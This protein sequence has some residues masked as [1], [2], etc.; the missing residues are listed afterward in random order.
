[1]GRNVKNGFLI[2]MNQF[3][4]SAV[5]L[6]LIV[7]SGC[8]FYEYG[9]PD[10]VVKEVRINFEVKPDMEIYLKAIP[11]ELIIRGVKGNEAVASMEARCPDPAGKCAEYFE[12]LEFETRLKDNRLTVKPNKGLGFKGN[13]AVKTILSIP[14]VNSLNV[15]M[16]AGETKISGINVSKLYLDM[17]AGEVY[18]NVENLKTS[19]NVDLGAG[20]VNITI[21]ED[22]VREVDVDAG[23]GDAS[24]RRNGRVENAPRS[25][26][27]GAETQQFISNEGAVVWVDVNVGNIQVNLTK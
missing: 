11:G 4:Y 23:I 18:I 14:A 17:T 7:L 22:S 2:I 12:D 26:L 24:I 6:G 19:L 10:E 20:D 13:R 25:F 1:M 15:K 16:K 9:S 27:L 3:V 5:F 8:S 21:P